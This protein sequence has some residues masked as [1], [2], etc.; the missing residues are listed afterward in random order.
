MIQTIFGSPVIIL[1]TDN[2]ENL[3]S[4]ELY[5]ETVDYLLDPNNNFIDHPQA[6]NGKIYTTAQTLNPK[7][8]ESI[9]KGSPL[10]DF[11]KICALDYAHLY[12][13]KTIEGIK[14]HASWCNL[15]YKGCEI[16]CHRDNICSPEKSLIIL[17]YA[18][19]PVNSSNLVF[20]HNS[21]DGDW[22]SDRPDKDLI[23][24]KV[25]EGDIIIIDSFIHHAV[26]PH[27][28]EL[29]RMCIAVEFKIETS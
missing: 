14:F 11:L 8:W 12:S 10:L 9:V 7:K 13:D 19:T 26:D 5:Q 29:P 4:K 28:S 16:S 25:D 21:K 17:F 22:P 2:V 20:I 1:K 18:K 24:V 27:G 15:T 23:R 6:R 3:F